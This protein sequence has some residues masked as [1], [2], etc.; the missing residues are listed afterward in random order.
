MDKITYP[1][2]VDLLSYQCSRCSLIF[3]ITHKVIFKNTL[4]EILPTETEI[5]WFNDFN[6]PQLDL[7]DQAKE[8]K[9]MPVKGA[10]KGQQ[11]SI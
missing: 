7:A 4:C 10:K 8:I 1:N 3:K 9:E 11:L 5:Q 6:C 2:K